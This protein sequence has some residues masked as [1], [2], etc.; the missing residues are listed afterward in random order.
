MITI[1]I[2]VLGRAH[3]IAPLLKSISAAT[4]VEHEVVF[5]CS[6][7]DTEARDA[8][9][10]SSARTL[11]ADWAPGHGDFARK[12]ALAYA[13][14]EGEWIFQGAT[15][16]EF[17]SGWDT[18]ALQ[19]AR[20]TGAL[21]IGTN[22]EGNP[23]VISGKHSTHTLIARSYCDDPGASMDGPRTVFSFEYQHNFTDSELVNLA[24]ARGV[25]SFSPGSIVRHNHVHWGLA[26]MD[27]TYELGLSG[28]GRDR[29]T[30]VKRRMLW[31]KAAR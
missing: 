18:A 24:K 12:I 31:A 26:P 13:S 17:S 27:Q 23:S 5:I 1:V 29:I 3:Q 20:E 4:S 22:D 8:C 16:I 6:P 30:F 19:V 21:V 14:T 11:I 7:N 2:P 28:F 9:L 15:D 10:A 25:W